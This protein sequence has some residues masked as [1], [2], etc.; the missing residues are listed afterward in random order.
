LDSKTCLSLVRDIFDTNHFVQLCG[1]IIDEVGCGTARLRMPVIA[2]KHTNLSG[3]V[4]GGALST[5]AN[6][7]VGVACSSAG[8]IVVTQSI[9]TN[10]I[11]NIKANHTAT[12]QAHI[13]HLGRS[14]VTVTAEVFDDQQ[15]LMCQTLASMFIKGHSEAIPAQW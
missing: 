10:F 2:E 7:A 11:R 15:H 12:C 4:H 5:L 3:N 13:T 8:C 1:I 9:T 14:T 6:T